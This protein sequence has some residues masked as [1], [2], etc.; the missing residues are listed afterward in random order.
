M[1]SAALVSWQ[2]ERS[3]HLDDLLEAHKRL[4]GPAPG[5]RWRTEALNDALILRLA[6]EFQGFVRDLH[7]QASDVF[8]SW[9]APSSPRTQSVVRKNLVG[10]R[11]LE[12]GNA[13]H[14]SIGADFGRFGFEI[15][16]ELHDLDRRTVE[17]RESLAMLNLARNG[18]AH[19]DEAKLAVLRDKGHWRVLDT[20]RRWRRD[21]DLLATN[22]DAVTADQ[23][24]RLFDRP[25]PW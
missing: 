5:R 9:I 6:A 16:P 12:R 8:A 18:L 10:G 17:H 13:R 1:A 7:D 14:E 2:E 22:L 21:L 3:T 19:S 23:L 25:R 11:E 20:F 4:G 15:W 24:A